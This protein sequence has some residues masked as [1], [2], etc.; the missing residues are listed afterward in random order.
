MTTVPSSLVVWNSAVSLPSCRQ[1][2]TVSDSPG[3]TGRL[4][5]PDMD[6]NLAGSPSHSACSRA[7]PVTP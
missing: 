3:Y 5:R 1:T 2:E 7:R 6:P 4:N